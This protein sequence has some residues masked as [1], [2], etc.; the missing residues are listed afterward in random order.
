MPE[1]RKCGAYFP[2]KQVVDGKPRVF[3]SR[4]FCLICSPFGMHNTRKLDESK[5]ERVH[6]CEVCGKRYNAGHRQYAKT[7][8]SCRSVRHRQDMKRKAVAHL[9]GQCQACGYDRCQAALHFHHN[10]PDEKEFTFANYSR[11]WE[12]LRTEI[13]KCVLLCSNCHVEV[14][15][16]LRTLEEI[17]PSQIATSC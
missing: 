17:T 15:A 10:N 9:G 12:R 7:C 16:G 3:T 11:S 13:E 6:V 8:Q 2:L 5:P 4:K 1:C 14:H